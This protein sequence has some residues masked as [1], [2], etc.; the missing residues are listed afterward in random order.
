MQQPGD[1]IIDLDDRLRIK[2]IEEKG[3]EKRIPAERLHGRNF[4][5]VFHPTTGGRL[6]DMEHVQ[7]EGYSGNFLSEEIKCDGMFIRLLP[8]EEGL[9]AWGFFYTFTHHEISDP[10]LKE[11]LS[12]H[13]D[14]EF[15]IWKNPDLS[16]PGSEISFSEQV[17]KIT[18]Y[19]P[20]ELNQMQGKLF[21]IVHRGDVTQVLRALNETKNNHAQSKLK[22]EYRL[23]TKSGDVIW[24]AEYCHIRRNLKGEAESMTGIVNDI[25]RL[26][27]RQFNLEESEVALRQLN[28][29]K[30]RFI[31]ILSH[32]LRG[33]YTSILGFAE[34]LLNEPDLP[35]HEKI[36]YL[37]YIYEASVN[38]LQFINYLLDWSRLRTG[39]IKPEFQRL[40]VHALV[41]N[42]V[43]NLT[44]NAIRKNIEIVI[45]VPLDL[46]VQADE[47][48]AAQAIV[49]LLNNAIK[50]SYE[51]SKIEVTAGLFNIRQVEFVVK[52]HGMGMTQEE[53]A[54][55]FSL[56]KFVS[57]EGSKG[58]KGSGF[59]LTLVKEIV[60]KHGGEIWF[61][62]E[63][64]NG[65]EFHFTLPVPAN[66]IM[67]IDPDPGVEG[68]L[69][70]IMVNEFRDYE[71]VAVENGYEAIDIL[72]ESA[73][74]LI[75][76]DK[77][78]PLMSC[79]QF[80]D[81]VNPAD[82]HFKTPII[83]VEAG[84]LDN[85]HNMGDRGVKALLRSPL[86]KSELLTTIR[87]IIN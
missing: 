77:N 22:L 69:R 6:L 75:I 78:M 34:I 31:N 67:I 68:S 85:P 63:E 5:E 25:T 1:F 21:S 13:T 35:E 8:K 15:F 61:Y 33:P 45:N 58:E 7:K 84:E 86:S 48:L 2:S 62:S 23:V 17:E 11:I 37:T 16:N 74:A 26:K 41:H 3:R 27:L 57:K 49:N 55:L 54:S 50:F 47:R 12:L 43:S 32:D 30:D 53:Q 40:P 79:D 19:T 42:C 72:K 36:E 46:H 14:I 80:I 28:D 4:R 65:S 87:S 44:G 83:L 73:P 64:D 76:A 39:K 10:G 82:S 29:S 18:G 70:S 51:N 9:T 71:V 20:T 52:D 24:V 60:E 59:G 56:D 66:T 81:S 38:Q